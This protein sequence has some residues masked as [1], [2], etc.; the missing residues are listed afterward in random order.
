MPVNTEQWHAGIGTF[1]GHIFF[2]SNKKAC[3]PIIIFKCF[4]IHFCPS[5]Y[6][7]LVYWI[8]PWTTQKVTFIRVPIVLG[9]WECPLPSNDFFW[10][11]TIKANHPHGAPPPSPIKNEA[12][13]IKKQ[14]PHW[15]VNHPSM[16]WF[17]E[18]A[19]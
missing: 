3:D 4:L 5:L 1:H 13:H 8:K 17:L 10:K 12:P 7:R 9:A 16:K 18:K 11:P 14:P 15:N 6:W 19:Q 2:F